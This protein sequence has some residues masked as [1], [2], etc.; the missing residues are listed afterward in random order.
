MN[1][2]EIDQSIIFLIQILPMLT[3]TPSVMILEKHKNEYVCQNDH[4]NR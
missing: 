2:V 1:I 3:L 4:K